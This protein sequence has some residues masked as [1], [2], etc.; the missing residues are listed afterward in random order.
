[1][2]RLD[3]TI[4]TPAHLLV[5]TLEIASLR[6]E[7]AT[8]S[9]GVRPGHVDFVTL[10]RA[11]VVRWRTPDDQWHYC[12]LDE[13]VLSVSGGVRVAIA[14]RDA[15][16]GDSLEQLD[17]LVRAN[18]AARLDA[19]RRARVDET[20]LHAETVRRLLTYLRPGGSAGDACDPFVAE[21][22]R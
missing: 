19:E 12:A 20:R 22:R 15:V 21:P 13:G 10:L 3:L 2:A 11:S 8:G 6:A 9:F 17:A 18:R 16:P 5:D 4:A 14:C 1:M 7:D